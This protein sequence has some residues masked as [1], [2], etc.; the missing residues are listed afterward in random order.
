MKTVSVIIPCYNQAHYLA[1]AI[2]SALNQTYPH[3]EIVVVNDGSTDDTAEVAA[4]YGNRLRYVEKANAG[5]SAAR[6]TAIENSRGELIALLDSD[7]RWLPHKLET[8]VRYFD[9][10]S[11]TALCFSSFNYFGPHFTSKMEERLPDGLV[12]DVH[13]VM[14]RRCAMQVPTAIFRRDILENVGG[15]N[16]AY[17][18]CEDWDM[19]LRIVLRHKVVIC[20]QVLAE[21]RQAEGSLSSSANARRVYLGRLQLAEAYSNIHK[22]CHVCQVA[23]Q[24]M[25]RDARAGYFAGLRTQANKALSNRQ[26]SQ[27]ISLNLKAV[28]HFP[29]AFMRLPSYR[30]RR[31]TA[32]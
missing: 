29:E 10:D 26:F 13:D 18:Y 12:L 9:D 31:P 16:P 7:D 4:R 23:I 22:D 2:E 28:A 14:L 20:G 8:Q 17:E 32:I 3:V 1:E 27:A 15:F 21:Y 19:W 5:L 24:K 25:R 6:N 11:T 30:R